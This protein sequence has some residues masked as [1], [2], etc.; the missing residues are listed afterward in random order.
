MSLAFRAVACH[1]PERSL[2]NEMLARQ[3]PEWTEAKIFKKTGIRSRCVVEEGVTALDL[4]EK[5]CGKLFAENALDPAAIDYLIFCTQSPDYGLPPNCALLQQRLGLPT[6]LGCFDFTHGCSGYV[7]GLSLASAVAAAGMGKNILLVTGETYSL[8]LD[9]EDKSTRAIF[10]DGATATFLQAHDGP[11][12]VTH[13]IFAT[14]GSG[15]RYLFSARG[16]MRKEQDGRIPLLPEEETAPAGGALHMRGPAI[17]SYTLRVVPAMLERLLLQARLAPEDVDMFLLHQAN[18][19]MLEHLRL[20]C[21]IPRDKFL[22]D[23]EHTGNTVSSSI[24]VALAKALRNG[25]VRPGHVLAL[26]GFGVGLSSA[27]CLLR[28]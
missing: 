2:T 14:D 15:G 13:C 10:G 11:P 27:A 8:R 6:T 3:F 26:A 20:K 18:A 21:A 24:P 12:A 7:Y 5:A 19:Y 28:L 22:V 1:L 25:R 23:L 16:G 9:P 17:F 4:A